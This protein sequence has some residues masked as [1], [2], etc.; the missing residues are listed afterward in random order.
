MNYIKTEFWIFYIFVISIMLSGCVVAPT[1]SEEQDATAKKF[2]PARGFGNVYIV[3]KMTLTG[4]GIVPGVDVDGQ[5]IGSI[6]PGTYHLLELKPGK[7]SISVT[8]KRGEDHE[9]VDVAEGENYFLEVEPD[10]FSWRTQASVERIDAEEGRKLV[11]KGKLLRTI[12]LKQTKPVTEPTLQDAIDAS[13]ADLA[14]SYLSMKSIVRLVPT[15]ARATIHIGGVTINKDN[16]DEYQVKFER[17]LSLYEQAIRQRGYKTISGLYK[18][19]ATESCARSNSIFAA[20]IQQQKQESIEIT[21]DDMD[22][23]IIITAKHDDKEVSITNPAAVAE[24][25]IAVNEATNSDYFFRGEI[26][27][28]VIVFKPHVSV[29]DTWPK[30][31]NPPS[32]RDLEEC[33]VTLERL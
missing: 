19:E 20:L 23:Q 16:V 12:P 13:A 32:R 31:A 11:S 15:G 33:I 21:Q 28:N 24:S 6:V 10:L 18:G 9:V 1:M 3:R 30:W 27:N 26:K 7:Y 14:Q 2:Q 29:L 4:S 5:S 17:R 8:T 22:A 25:V